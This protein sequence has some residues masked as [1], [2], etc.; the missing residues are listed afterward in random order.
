MPRWSI[1]C[2]CVSYNQ[3]WITPLGIKLFKRSSYNGRDTLNEVVLSAVKRFVS[4]YSNTL[5]YCNY[6]VYAMLFA[7]VALCTVNFSNNT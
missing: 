5:W 2:M 6:M 3:L 7:V 4:L 1:S